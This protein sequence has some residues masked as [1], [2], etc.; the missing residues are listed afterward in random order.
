M[1]ELS[2]EDARLE[3]A[4]YAYAYCFDRQNFYQVNEAF[5]YTTSP[6]KLNNALGL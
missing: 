2:Y 3:V 5:A 6:E 4:Q 1:K